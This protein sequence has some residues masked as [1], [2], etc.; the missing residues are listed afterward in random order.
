M[1]LFREVFPGNESRSSVVSQ[2]SGRVKQS[3]DIDAESHSRSSIW[4]VETDSVG[5][6]DGSGPD[7]IDLNAKKR[8]TVSRRV[9]IQLLA[10]LGA[11]ASN[12]AAPADQEGRYSRGHGTPKAG[13]KATDGAST[14][15]VEVVPR[16]RFTDAR[17]S[18]S[19]PEH[20]ALRYIFA[21][22]P[23]VLPDS[24]DLSDLLRR[25]NVTHDP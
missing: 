11:R 6:S 10:P 4:D 14:R 13:G 1:A 3:G 17:R 24:L 25:D 16:S 9:S 8:L 23:K 22:K 20:A 21:A 2:E 19:F 18:Q 5:D 15:G 7:I 12:R